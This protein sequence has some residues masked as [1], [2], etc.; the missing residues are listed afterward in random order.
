MKYCKQ[1]KSMNI[2]L[3][4]NCREKNILEVVLSDHLR[5]SWRA[6]NKKKKIQFLHAAIIFHDIYKI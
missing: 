1:Q 5:V 2:N 3:K 4:K 6:P